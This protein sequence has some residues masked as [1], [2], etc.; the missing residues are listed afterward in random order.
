MTGMTICIFDDPEDFMREV[1]SLKDSMPVM[2]PRKRAGWEL[3]EQARRYRESEDYVKWKELAKQWKI[4]DSKIKR[5]VY[6]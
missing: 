3:R 1:L 4:R 2:K 6:T 5:K